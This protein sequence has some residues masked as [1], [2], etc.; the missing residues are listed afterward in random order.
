MNSLI[1]IKPTDM[2]CFPIITSTMVYAFSISLAIPSSHNHFNTTLL[3]KSAACNCRGSFWIANF[4]KITL[5]CC[6]CYSRPACCFGFAVYV[7]ETDVSELRSSLIS[8][9][10]SSIDFYFCI[11]F[12]KFKSEVLK[13]GSIIVLALTGDFLGFSGILIGSGIGSLIGS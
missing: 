9:S 8:R 7:D 10:I 3:G 2:V 5:T 12:V 13:F 1:L 4:W 11:T 6:A